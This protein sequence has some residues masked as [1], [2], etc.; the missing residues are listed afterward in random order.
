MWDRVNDIVRARDGSRAAGR[1]QRRHHPR[2]RA[3]R[4]VPARRHAGSA[5][6]TRRWS[7]R[8]G[9]ARR[10][11]S[12]RPRGASRTSPSSGSSSPRRRASRARCRS[13][14]ATVRAGRSSS[15][16]RSVRSSA[17]S[18][19]SR[20][21]RRRAL[22][23]TT[24]RSTR[25][26]GQHRAQYLDEQ[27]EATGVVPDD[28]TVVVERFRDEI[29]DWR[30]CI[31]SPFGTPVHAPWAMAIERRLM[32]RYDIAG[33]DDVG[34]RRHRAPPARGRR[35]AAARR[36]DHRPRR[37][38]RARRV[39]AAADRRCSPPASA[40]APV[41]RCCCRAAG[42]TGARRCGSSAS[43]PPTC[44]RSRRSTRRS[45]S[46]SRRR[47]SAAGRV[48][49]AGAARGARPAAQPGDPG[50][51]RRHGEG[52]PVRAEPAVQLDR[53]VH[54]RG[55]RA[56]GRA[57]GRGA[58]ARPRPAARPARCR[59]A[60]RAARPRRA[61]RRRARAAVPHRGPPGAQPP[62]SC[63]TCSARSATS[64]PPRS[65]CA[66]KATTAAA[67]LAELVHERRVDRAVGRPASP[68][69]RRRGRGPLPRRA[70]VRAAARPARGVH[71]TGRALPLESLVGRYARTHAPFVVDDVARRL[72]ASDRAGRRRARG[73]RGRR[74]RRARR[75]PA[76]RACSRE[77]CDV[78]VLR[79]LRRRSLAALRR[80]VEPVEPDAYARFLT[81]WHNIPGERRGL[82]ALVEAL[83]MLQ[84]AA[85]V[86]CSLETDVLPLRVRGY[87]PTDLDELCTAGE[88]VWVGAGSIGADR[89]PD[90]A[91]LRRSAAAARAGDRE[92]LEPPT[93]P[94]ARRDPCVSWRPRRQLLGRQVARGRRRVHRRRAARRA[95]GPGVGGRGHQRLAGAAARRHRHGAAPKPGTRAASTRLAAG[96]G[97]VGSRASARPRVPGG[98]A[99]SRRCCEPVP[100]PHRGRARDRR[101]SCSS[102]TA[103]SPARRC[104]PKAWSGGFAA[105][106]AC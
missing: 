95:V 33:R 6:S 103:S 8:A 38:R 61:R 67:W 90:P 75:V 2:P 80:E 55:R 82:E 10:S 1:H 51:Q 25:S 105:C 93:G 63:T 24:T 86:A 71:R 73:A 68:V 60:A 74:A 21:A 104:S 76:R 84:G 5:S 43:V 12:A 100:D 40:S 23:T 85:L 50:R 30:V 81:S 9:R 45:R 72:G 97:P 26:R 64:P 41:A 11:C 17:R 39:L 36:A 48:R 91:V 83:G 65:T 22:C 70:R 62:T 14:T 106:T 57:A 99:W 28:R 59:G 96:R 56:A 49:P 18:A 77:W 34:R 52:S 94:A 44:W 92:P 87:R 66:A 32:D 20:R 58:G 37:H 16:A 69:H 4:C 29:G 54:V 27:A 79:Q 13:G 47:A 102:A 7:T 46:C 35:R 15:A 88:V 31:L 19:R 101:C 42:P 3:V 89:R 98:G 78:D 53:R